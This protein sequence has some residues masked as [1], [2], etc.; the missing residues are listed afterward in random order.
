VGPGWPET[1]MMTARKNKTISVDLR[2]MIIEIGAGAKKRLKGFANMPKSFKNLPEFSR[3]GWRQ[4][5]FI[6]SLAA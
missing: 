5:P 4:R 3:A 1:W 6:I 2:C